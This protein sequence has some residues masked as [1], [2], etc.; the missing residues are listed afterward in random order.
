MLSLYRRVIRRGSFAT[1]TG[2]AFRPR[3]MEMGR[4]AWVLFALCLFYVFAAVIL[5][6]GRCC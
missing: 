3:P 4:M 2:K 1:I 5:P 6:L